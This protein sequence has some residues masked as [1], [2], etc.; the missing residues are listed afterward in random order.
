MIDP[1]H[2]C[3]PSTPSSNPARHPTPVLMVWLV[4]SKISR[5]GLWGW[6]SLLPGIV[7]CI[8]TSQRLWC[9]EVPYFVPC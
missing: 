5:V 1:P 4:H 7:N 2:I 6:D 3:V 8:G 9:L